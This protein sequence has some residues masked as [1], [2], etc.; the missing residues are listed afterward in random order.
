MMS[1]GRI[2]IGEVGCISRTSR[3]GLGE[4][5]RPAATSGAAAGDLDCTHRQHQTALTKREN[6]P[7]QGPDGQRHQSPL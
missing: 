5:L 1:F 4:N 3:Y 2:Q 6:F 7:R